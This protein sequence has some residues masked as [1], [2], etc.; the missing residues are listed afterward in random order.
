MLSNTHTQTNPRCA[1]AP[2]VNEHPKGIVFIII[3]RGP[4]TPPP[5]GQGEPRLD[6][7]YARITSRGPSLAY[8]CL[9]IPRNLS[10]ISRNLCAPDLNPEISW[11]NLREIQKSLGISRNLGKSFSYILAR[12]ITLAET[13]A[14]APEC[15]SLTPRQSP[16]L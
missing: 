13:F 3:A 10:E 15:E 4:V 2:R 8:T 11:V 16:C 6:N 7:Y 9:E 1:C 5:F 14:A 12:A